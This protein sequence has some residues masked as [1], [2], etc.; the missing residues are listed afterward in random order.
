MLTR[1]KLNRG[2]G[3]LVETPEVGSRRRK[4]RSPKSPPPV[5]PRVIGET[6]V[7][8]S[9]EGETTNMTKDDNIFMNYFFD[10]TNMVTILYEERNTRL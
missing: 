9:H 1:L 7:S 4:A 8:I 6:L 10:M 5:L 2:E 3:K